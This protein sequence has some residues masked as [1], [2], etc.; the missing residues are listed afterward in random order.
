MIGNEYS[1]LPVAGTLFHDTAV[2]RYQKIVIAQ[3]KKPD[4]KKEINPKI[5]IAC[6]CTINIVGAFGIS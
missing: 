6:F 1:L 5:Q 4:S 3:N 2:Y